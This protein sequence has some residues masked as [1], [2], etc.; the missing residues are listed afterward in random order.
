MIKNDFHPELEP[1]Y[2]KSRIRIVERL[3]K[4]FVVFFLCLAGFGVFVA[5]MM[6]VGLGWIMVI[7]CGGMALL[8]RW[9][10]GMDRKEEE[11]RYRIGT[12]LLESVPPQPMNFNFDGTWHQYPHGWIANL[13]DSSAPAGKAPIK[14]VLT[15][16]PEKPPLGKSKVWVYFKAN[17]ENLLCVRI[18]GKI[19]MGYRL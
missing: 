13:S 7:G 12:E 3:M 2:Q 9:I 8:L 1:A 19:S 16:T 18:K 11:T 5:V 10:N 4:V 14:V 15:I 6:G 17:P